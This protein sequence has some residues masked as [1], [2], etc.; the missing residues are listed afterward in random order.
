MHPAVAGFEPLTAAVTG[1]PRPAGAVMLALRSRRR[2][3]RDT[4]YRARSAWCRVP[5]AARE[6]SVLLEMGRIPLPT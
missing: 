2:V 4:K 3:G 1:L 6:A 5:N